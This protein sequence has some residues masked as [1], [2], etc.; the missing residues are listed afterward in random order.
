M[1]ATAFSFLSCFSLLRVQWLAQESGAWSTGSTEFAVHVRRA[2]EHL[3]LHFYIAILNTHMVWP[4][5]D[6]L[7]PIPDGS[8]VQNW[9]VV[10][11]SHHLLDLPPS[12][13]CDLHSNVA[14]S[15]TLRVHSPVRSCSF[16]LSVSGDFTWHN[17]L[18]SQWQGFLL[19]KVGWFYIVC[20]YSDFLSR[21][22]LW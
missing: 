9:N 13:P 14:V 12:G 5:T 2:S 11:L 7:W 16:C 1:V 15:L 6:S 21:H 10:P 20:A 22:L 3:G 19:F 8:I 18:R 17:A 4:A